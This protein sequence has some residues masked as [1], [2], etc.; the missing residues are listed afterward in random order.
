MVTEA[1]GEEDIREAITSPASRRFPA[2]EARTEAVVMLT[3]TAHEGAVEAEEGEEG[4]ATETELQANLR[5]RHHWTARIL[6]QHNH[7]RSLEVEA[8][9]VIA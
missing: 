2:T 7:H 9:L 8:F 5:Q 1:E 6:R 3:A 4:V